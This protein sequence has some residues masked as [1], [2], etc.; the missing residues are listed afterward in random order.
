MDS[1]GTR[2]LLL[3]SADAFHSAPAK[4]AWDKKAQAFSLTR[5]DPPRLPRLAPD[6]GMALWQAAT[7]LVLDDHGQLGRLSPDRLRFEFSLTWPA[8][9]WQVV[10]A[11]RADSTAVPDTAAALTLDPVEA[12]PGTTFTDLHLGGSGLAALTYSDGGTGNGLLLV[13]LRKRWQASC[14]LPFI[15]VRVW[16]DEEDQIWVA[17]QAV[18]GLYRGGPLPQPY[19]ARA[20]RFEPVQINPDPLRPLW[21]APVPL[22]PHRGLMGLAGNQDHL[23]LL[24]LDTSGTA[25][26]PLQTLLLRPR[27]ASPQTPFEAH[28]IPAGLPLATDLAVLESGEI[29]LLVPFEEGATRGKERDCPLVSL[30]LDRHGKA[31]PAAVVNERWPRRTEAGVRFV[32]HR[33]GAVRHLAEDGVHR[34]FR[35]AQAHY[36]TEGHGT[37]RLPL[38]SGEPG[39]IWHRLYLEAHIPTG[40]TLQVVAQARDAVEDLSDF[41]EDRTQDA[42]AVFLRKWDTQP[43]PLRSPLASEQPF[44]AARVTPDQGRAGLYEILLQRPNGAVRDLAGRYLQLGLTLQGDG[45]HTPAI[46]AMRVYHPRFSWQ[47][48]YLPDHF[49]QQEL[50]PML[51]PLEPE[52]ANAADVRERLLACF[53]GVLTPIEDRIAASEVLVSPRSAPA[54]LLPM[55]ASLLGASLPPQWPEL[56]QRAWLENI[57]YLQRHK[58]TYGGLCRALDLLTDGAV[59]AGRVVPVENFRL[60]RTL[61]TILGISLDDESHPLTLGTGLS[62]NSIVGDTLILSDDDSREFLALFAPSLGQDADRKAV[63]RFFDA[64]ARKLTIVLHGPARPLRK[65]IEAALPDLLP[66]AIQWSFV[67]TDHPF[68]LGLSPLL[69]IDTYLEKEPP[70]GRVVLNQTRLG[71]GDLLQNPVALSPEHAVPVA[72]TD[73]EGD[74]G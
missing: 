44:A 71:R 15:P 22:P 6:Q 34:L 61:S 7:P 10:R 50:G 9:E 49:H 54:T 23:C 59:R 37:L 36:P 67:E 1:N 69:N 45:R 29:M 42:A 62:G 60:R 56:R 17:G 30:G 33:D 19:Q 55:L 21:P 4:C 53:E 2:F 47:R 39:T 20:D 43:E 35:L 51:G 63:N 52:A 46:Y 13:H 66:A 70:S 38:D 25:G 27:L 74:W 3:N 26:K 41:L 40:C 11:S 31:L 57:G 64:Y 73:L 48:N 18:L 58:G 8:P 28:P 68:V 65:V 32:R 24:A 14:D 16:V 12:P 5:Q 72:V